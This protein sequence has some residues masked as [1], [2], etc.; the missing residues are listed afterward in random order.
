M[1]VGVI[2]CGSG[3][4]DGSEIHESVL[5]LLHLA[6]GGAEAAC[7]APD[8]PQWAVCDHFSGKPRPGETRNMLQEAAR[9]AR[10]A[11]RPLTEARASD[12]DALILPG[13]NGAAHNLGGFASA[14]ARGTVL[15]DLERLLL[16]MVEAGKPIGAICIAPALVAL[17]LGARAPLLTLGQV[18]DPA[19]VEAAKTG[20]R[21]VDCPVDGSV[22]DEAL[23]L[24]STPAY[25]LAQSVAEA[26]AGIGK[27]VAEVLR[28]ARKR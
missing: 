26:D 8:A 15:P 2:L 3:R 13:G 7:F 1:R 20:A 11:V 14:G 16:A 19:A 17:A 21:L 25:M 28:R 5:T 6:R 24:V 9:I 27:L 22:V 10:G 23:N 12:L 4:F 18:S